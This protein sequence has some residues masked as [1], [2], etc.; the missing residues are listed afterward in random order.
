MATENQNEQAEAALLEKVRAEVKN[1]L[2]A[3]GDLVLELKGKN[4]KLEEQYNALEEK[5][6]NTNTSD[7]EEFKSVKEEVTRLAGELKAAKENGMSRK[8]VQTIGSLLKENDSKIKDFMNKKSG[9]IILDL[10]ATQTSGDIGS[11]DS[12]DTLGRDHWGQWHEG[13][14]VG[15]IPTRQ[16]FMQELFK[17]APAKSEY[18]RYVDQDTVVRDA[19]N[20]AGCAASTHNTKVT[21]KKHGINIEKVRDFVHIC[22]DMLEDYSFVESEIRNL[23]TSS[24]ELKV[25]NDLLLGTGVSPIING[26]AKYASTFSASASGA[27]YAGLV[28]NANVIDLLSVAG[29]QIKAFGQQNAFRP[30]T[31]ALNPKDKQLIQFLK[32]TQGDYLNTN[33]MFKG[34][35]TVNGDSMYINGMRVIEN[36]LVAENTAYVFDSTKGTIYYKPGVGIEFSYE[37][38]DNFET[39]TVTVKA[40]RRL[41]MLVRNVDINAFMFIPDLLAAVASINKI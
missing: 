13:G 35:I 31:I 24:V 6:K 41:N 21:F 17:T 5:A 25:D 36:P 37:N 15:Q 11:G 8:L 16:P 40:F 9:T 26:V 12:W 27:S 3:T 22:D 28:Q 18:I 19:K 34:V 10:K 23:I 33:Q 4:A 30:N 39:E 14:K 32:N 38:R 2:K 1:E 29:A 20:V 7:P